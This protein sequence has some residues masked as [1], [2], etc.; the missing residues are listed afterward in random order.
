MPT[1]IIFDN[2]TAGNGSIAG[3]IGGVEGKNYRCHAGGELGHAASD[4]DAHD[5]V[6]LSKM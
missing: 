3:R 6:L 2:E 4:T 5:A 1:A